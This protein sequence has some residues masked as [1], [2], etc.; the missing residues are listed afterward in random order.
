MAD[1][2]SNMMDV[3]YDIEIDADPGIDMQVQEPTLV[4]LP[5]VLPEASLCS[6]TY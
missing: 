2:D 6:V 4:R 3:D 1:M 5:L